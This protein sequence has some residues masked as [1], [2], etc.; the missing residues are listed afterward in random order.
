[1]TQCVFVQMFLLQDNLSGCMSLHT[2]H[3]NMYWRSITVLLLKWNPKR[4]SSILNKTSVKSV[5]MTGGRACAL[6]LQLLQVWD[7]AIG[8]LCG[9]GGRSYFLILRKHEIA[10]SICDALCFDGISFLPE[11]FSLSLQKGQSP[12]FNVV[13]GDYRSY[14]REHYSRLN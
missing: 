2:L 12:I 5:R 4:E 6:I 11:V 9:G 1:M 13:V 7:A 14:K 8:H 10:Q 3:C